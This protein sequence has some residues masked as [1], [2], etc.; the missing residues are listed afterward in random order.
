MTEGSES[1]GTLAD[2]RD[3]LRKL[4]SLASRPGV[5][6]N[7]FPAVSQVLGR[8]VA[9]SVSR[10]HVVH[11]A[12]FDPD[13]ELAI[14]S[15]WTPPGGLRFPDGGGHRVASSR[16]STILRRSAEPVTID[17]FRPSYSVLPSMTARMGI[18]VVTYLPLVVRGR[19]WGEM[20]LCATD[21][22]A[23]VSGSDTFV[24]ALL[25]LIAVAIDNAETRVEL[26]RS[27]ARIVAA[28]DRARWQIERNL[29][30]GAQQRFVSLAVM[31]QLVERLM[32]RGEISRAESLLLEAIGHLH[33][34]LDELTEL[35]RGIH[36]RVLRT[37]GLGGALAELVERAG[38]PAILEFETDDDLDETVELAAFYLVSEALT[39][40][41]K[42]ADANAAV[43]RVDT[44]AGRLR[45]I[46]SDDGGGGARVDAGTGL[47]GLSDRLQAVGG[48]L[49]VD[50]QD[51]RGTVL[52]ATL[53]LRASGSRVTEVAQDRQHAPMIE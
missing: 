29:H 50:S 37:R 4:T 7:L 28:S 41:A 30:D 8:D 16:G 47:T 3:V 1:V 32:S 24:A 6:R 13:D 27:R 52:R 35:A 38:L 20:M 44:E 26:G 45:V 22:P 19:L 12:R 42:H 15:G 2:Q 34:G 36:P 33:G 18:G 23:L 53:P 43:I 49:T 10:A 5:P 31:L 9:G 25:E 17:E 48:D 40:V 46:V 39:N 11:L 21:A 51:G 14:V